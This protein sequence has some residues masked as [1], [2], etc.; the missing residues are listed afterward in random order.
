M[1]TAPRVQT[2]DGD[3]AGTDAAMEGA[4]TTA[5]RREILDVNDATELGAAMEGAVTT[6]PRTV[7]EPD[8]N[9]NRCVPQWREP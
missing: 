2:L 3:V 5:P 7:C 9:V 1:T 4:V 8:A 6:A